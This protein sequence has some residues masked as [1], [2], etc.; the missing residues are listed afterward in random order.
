M[1]L[2]Q[3]PC[4]CATK[5]IVDAAAPGIKADVNAPEA[6]YHITHHSLPDYGYFCAGVYYFTIQVSRIWLEFNIEMVKGGGSWWCEQSAQ[7]NGHAWTSIHLQGY[8]G[9]AQ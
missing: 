6:P 1:S 3:R 2:A 8:N 5:A 7:F 4:L 9:S